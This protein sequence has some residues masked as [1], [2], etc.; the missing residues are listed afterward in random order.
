MG[1]LILARRLQQA[2]AAEAKLAAV[3]AFAAAWRNEL[4]DHFE[5]EERLLL[6]LGLPPRLRR[7][8]LAEHAVLRAMA[9][10]CQREPVR[11]AA[12]PGTVRQ[13]GLLLRDHIRWEERVLFQSVQRKHPTAVDALTEQARLIEQKRPASR[14]RHRLIWSPS[15][16]GEPASSS[17]E[18]DGSSLEHGKAIRHG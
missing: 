16:D 13:L 12:E 1:G 14:A 11:V 6:P 10:R 8:L 5:D 18:A 2:A 4:R 17:G 3:S 15:G 7:R 9:K